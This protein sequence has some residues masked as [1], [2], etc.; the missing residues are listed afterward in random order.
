MGDLVWYGF[1]IPQRDYELIKKIAEARGMTLAD[2]LRELIRRELARLSYLSKE[3]KKALGYSGDE[4]E[5]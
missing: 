4:H 1:R 5:G 3:E 2:L